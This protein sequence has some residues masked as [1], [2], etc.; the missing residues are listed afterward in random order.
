MIGSGEERVAGGRG[1]G[2]WEVGEEGL[3]KECE[4]TGGRRD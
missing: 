4:A 1:R 2:E 3:E